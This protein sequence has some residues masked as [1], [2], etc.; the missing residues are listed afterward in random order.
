MVQHLLHLQVGRKGGRLLEHPSRPAL[1]NSKLLESQLGHGRLRLH[2]NIRSC[3]SRRN[4]L[5]HSVGRACPLKLILLK[6]LGTPVCHLCPLC[7]KDE[8][9]DVARRLCI[10]F[11]RRGCAVSNTFCLLYMCITANLALALLSFELTD[12]LHLTNKPPPFS[13]NFRNLRTAPY[14][15]KPST[16]VSELLTTCHR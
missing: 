1:E 13:F 11:T 3:R 5:V 9:T 16:N 8:G 4:E 6:Q 12:S 7:T 15:I 2:S 14:N 10:I